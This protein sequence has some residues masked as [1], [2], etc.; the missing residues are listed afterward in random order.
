MV[1]GKTINTDMAKK[2]FIRCVT[3]QVGVD[4]LGFPIY[5]QHDIYQDNPNQTAKQGNSRK[6]KWVTVITNIF[7]QH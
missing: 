5:V 4:V 1:H 7:K 3:F 6:L 2:Q